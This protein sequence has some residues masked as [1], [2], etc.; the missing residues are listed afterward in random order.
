MLMSIFFRRLNRYLFRLHRRQTVCSSENDRKLE[1]QLAL[2]AVPMARPASLDHPGALISRKRYSSRCSNAGEIHL[3]QW[4]GFGSTMREALTS[5]KAAARSPARD[6]EA[7]VLFARSDAAVRAV[8]RGYWLSLRN[9]EEMES[10]SPANGASLPSSGIPP[11][12]SAPHDCN[13]DKC[14]AQNLAGNCYS[15]VHA[16]ASG[17]RRDV[18]ARSK[19]CLLTHPV[20]FRTIRSAHYRSSC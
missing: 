11:F 12:I 13:F 17:C 4:K 20:F 18:F 8:V 16:Y 2:S 1:F 10:L 15:K 6:S 3:K 19:A 9:L 7:T 14:A 5:T